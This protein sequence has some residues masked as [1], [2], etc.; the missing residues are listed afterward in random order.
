MEKIVRVVNDTW[1]DKGNIH[2]DNA[3]LGLILISLWFL[4]E[5]S[6]PVQNTY[7]GSD[8]Y[9]RA[10]FEE[11]ILSLLSSMK[12]AQ[13]ANLIPN[14]ENAEDASHE[15]VMPDDDSRK[16]NHLGVMVSSALTTGT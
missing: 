16:F 3:A 4:V 10:R 6:R 15:E 8:D 14:M 7:L 2:W 13:D 11:Y 1:D 12:H 5:P 9:L